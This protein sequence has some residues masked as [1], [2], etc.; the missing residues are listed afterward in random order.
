MGLKAPNAWG[1]YDMLG[2]VWEWC[3]DWTNSTITLP[4]DEAVEP[5]GLLIGQ[6]QYNQTGGKT[7]ERIKR[8]GS[9]S[10]QARSS[11][12]ASRGMEDR[13]SAA[14]HNTGFRVIAPITLKW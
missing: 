2:N 13:N 6:T 4:G 7:A 5:F 11:R 12:C 14:I 8:G 9:Y 10:N 1:L 3:L